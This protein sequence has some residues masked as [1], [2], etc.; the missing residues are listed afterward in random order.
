MLYQGHRFLGGINHFWMAVSVWKTNLVVEDI[1]RQKRKKMWPKC[2]IF[3]GLNDVW[4]S[5]WSLVCWIWIAKPSTKFRPSND[6]DTKRQSSECH[7]SNSPRPR[8]ERSNSKINIMLICCFDSQ[9]LVPKEFV[10]PGHNVN[11][12]YYREVLERLRKR[13]FVSY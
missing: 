1:V 6:P 10:L 9:G 4:Q 5:D 11:K 13:F 12:Q 8:K 2:G 7:S 3:W